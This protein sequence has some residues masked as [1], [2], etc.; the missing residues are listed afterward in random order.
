M[1]D[2]GHLKDKLERKLRESK[3]KDR[4]FGVNVNN[5]FIKINDLAG[6]RI[7]HLHTEQAA[8]IDKGLRE[9]FEEESYNLVEGPTARTW[10]DESRS[11]FKSVNIKT[12]ASPSLYTSI[13]YV[14]KPNRKTRYTCEIQ[15]RTLMEEV[16]GEVDHAINYP[17]QSKILGCRE[18]IRA[19]ARATSACSRLVDSIFRTH[20]EA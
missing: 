4:A 8:D 11:Y 5:L 10:D 12:K 7:L 16:W 3:S 6:L 19:L 2:P 18:Q 14:I 1:K 15:V 20:G 13:H 17:H 9:L